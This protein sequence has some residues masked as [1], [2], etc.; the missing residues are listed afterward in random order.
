MLS[1]KGC[2]FINP[3]EDMEFTTLLKNRRSIREYLDK[4][5]ELGTIKAII[6][7]STLAPNAGSSNSWKLIIIQDRKLLQKLSDYSKKRLLQE[8]SSKP[9]SP[10]NKYKSYLQNPKYNI[11][12]NAP[13]LVLIAS[14][15][16]QLALYEDVALYTAYFMFSATAKGL[17]TCFIGFAKALQHSLTLKKELGLTKNDEII[18]PII[19]GYPK[20]IPKASKRK[21]PLI[22]KI[23]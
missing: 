8:L 20:R 6:K 9:K 11:F 3:G 15:K 14:T 16:D 23:I 5:V 7:E 12:Y 18:A 21:A 19:I 17:G 22:T 1:S 4:K 13:T 10:F 2:Y